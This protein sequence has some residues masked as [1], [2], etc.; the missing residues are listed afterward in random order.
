MKIA[1]VGCCHGELTLLYNSI[2]S[3]NKHSPNKISLVLI[4]GDFQAIRNLNDLESMAVPQKYK[5]LGQFYL[6]HFEQS[7]VQQGDVRSIY[8]VRESSFFKL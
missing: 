6:G 7:P 4:C 1:V 5:R 2:V 8:H 3:L